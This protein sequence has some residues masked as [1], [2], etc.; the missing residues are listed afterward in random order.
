MSSRTH[1]LLPDS[2]ILRAELE[3]SFQPVDLLVVADLEED[4]ML[5]GTVVL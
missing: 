1:R 2:N 3:T 5:T 4:R